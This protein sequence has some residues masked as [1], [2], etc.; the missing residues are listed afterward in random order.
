[1]ASYHPVSWA[2]KLSVEFLSRLQQFYGRRQIYIWSFG[3]FWI[4][5]IPCAVSSNIQTMLV[6]H[7]FGGF[8][9]SAFLS[10]SG[11]T[12]GDMFPP[13]ELS[14]PMMIFTASPFLGLVHIP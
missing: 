7:F 9:G 4:W 11:G 3:G 14:A 1:M 12:I 6:A 2:V 8:A 10:V 5:L 13:H